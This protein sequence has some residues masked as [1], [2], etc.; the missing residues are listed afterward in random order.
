MIIT[1]CDLCNKP[2]TGKVVRGQFYN[3]DNEVQTCGPV[4][5]DMNI[6]QDCFE[7]ILEKPPRSGMAIEAVEKEPEDKSKYRTSKLDDGKIWD[8]YTAKAP[9]TLKAIAE[10]MGV[11]ETTIYNHIKRM[12]KEKGV[13]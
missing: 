12:R 3:Y 7:K 6:C 13:I 2:I 5:K 8:L 1:M 4:I 11:S 9:W 10:E